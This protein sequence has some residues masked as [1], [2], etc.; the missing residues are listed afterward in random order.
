MPKSLFQKY[1]ILI[2][3]KKCGHLCGNPAPI[4]SSKFLGVHTV[5]AL[6]AARKTKK[7]ALADLEGLRLDFPE[8]FDADRELAD[9][10][11]EKYGAAD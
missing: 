6:C 4:A 5:H 2:P 9:A 10:P 1:V 3:V 8:N 7:A 11:E